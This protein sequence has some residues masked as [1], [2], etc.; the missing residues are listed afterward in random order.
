MDAQ[1]NKFNKVRNLL[2]FAGG[3]MQSLDSTFVTDNYTGKNWDRMGEI[4]RGDN[5]IVRQ[6]MPQQPPHQYLTTIQEPTYYHHPSTYIQNPV[7]HSNNYQTMNKHISMTRE[8]RISRFLGKSTPANNDNKQQSLDKVIQTAIAPMEERLE[9]VSVLLGLV[10][11]RLEQLINIV[12]DTPQYEQSSQ[13]QH[14][15]VQQIPFHEEEESTIDAPVFD[16]GVSMS[17]VEDENEAA[18]VAPVSKKRKKK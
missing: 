11:Q 4:E 17:L 9:D 3:G 15:D 2:A 8:D 7:E 18:Q 6:F 13:F 16:P 14:D 12:D 5:M 1:Q 10:V